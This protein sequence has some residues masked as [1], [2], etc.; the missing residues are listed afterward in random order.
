MV[1]ALDAGYRR[2]F[3]PIT[4]VLLAIIMSFS[5]AL[6]RDDGFLAVSRNCFKL[7]SWTL[8]PLSNLNSSC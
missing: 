2:T 1:Y 3:L 6:G 8:K 7:L 5:S 4:L